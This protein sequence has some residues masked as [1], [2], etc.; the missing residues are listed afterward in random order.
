[1]NVVEVWDAKS[2]SHGSGGFI[3]SVVARR[4]AI[5]WQGIKAWALARNATRRRVAYVHSR[6]SGYSLGVEEIYDGCDR[7]NVLSNEYV[8]WRARGRSLGYVRTSVSYDSA[9]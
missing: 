4:R 7:S 5:S 8:V 3:Y 2:T 1:M 6:Y 9:S